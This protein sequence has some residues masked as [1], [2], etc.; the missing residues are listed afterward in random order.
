MAI[1]SIANRGKLMKPEIVKSVLNNENDVIKS[2]EPEVMSENFVSLS[3]IDE[4]REGMRQTVVSSAGTARSL[5]YLPVTSAAKTGTA[6]TGK[7]EV[8]HNWITIFAPY[9]DPEIVLTVIAESVP[10]NTGVA[11]LVSRE[12]LGYYFG[13][14]ERQQTDQEILNEGGN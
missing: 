3:A 5:Q 6:E 11:N 13:E 9:D 2:F 10:V 14:K 7:K 4:V 8:Y 1:S 12:I